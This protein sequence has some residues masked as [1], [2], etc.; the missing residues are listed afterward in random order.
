MQSCLLNNVDKQKMN[1]R[2]THNAASGVACR[3]L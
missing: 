1:Q 3:G 2:Q